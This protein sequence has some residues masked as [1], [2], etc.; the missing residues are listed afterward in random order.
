MCLNFSLQFSSV[1]QSCLTL[2][3]S[4]D[5]SMPGFP[6]L[7]LLLELAQTHVH[8]VSD[9]IQPS[10]SLLFPSPPAFKLSQHQSLFQWV[11][12]LDQVAKVLEFQLQLSALR[13]FIIASSATLLLLT[14]KNLNLLFINK[15]CN[16]L[17][18]S[19]RVSLVAHL[20]K[21]P[22]AMRETWIRSLGWEHHLEKGKATHCSIPA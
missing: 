2:C 8:W 3:D 9:A 7:H 12:S 19:T 22:P 21:N 20:V 13:G 1:A 10:H 11:S 18:S 5:C 17:T 4:M 6:V 15:I 14:K 16:D